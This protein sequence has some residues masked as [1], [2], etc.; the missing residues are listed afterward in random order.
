MDN[1]ICTAVAVS[2]LSLFI[3]TVLNG[4][5][6]CDVTPNHLNTPNPAVFPFTLPAAA[7]RCLTAH[8][9]LGT[10]SSE[11]SSGNRDNQLPAQ[12]SLLCP[13]VVTRPPSRTNTHFARSISSLSRY[14]T[15]FINPCNSGVLKVLSVR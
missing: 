15:Y 9:E 11:Y 2:P 7:S 5:P 4:Y 6:I 13:S 12:L 8:D 1:F 14:I 10:A 3:A